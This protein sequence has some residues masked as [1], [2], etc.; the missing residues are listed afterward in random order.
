MASRLASAHTI[1]MLRNSQHSP[2]PPGL[3]VA[4]SARGYMERLKSTNPMPRRRRIAIIR[5]SRLSG[6]KQIGAAGGTFLRS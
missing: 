5:R 2:N 1:P 4:L 6:C 3:V